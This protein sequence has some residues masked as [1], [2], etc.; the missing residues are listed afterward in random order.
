MRGHLGL[1]T[2]V[3]LDKGHRI[4]QLMEKHG[5]HRLFDVPFGD[6][7]TINRSLAHTIRR[8]LDAHDSPRNE[9]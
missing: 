2:V 9:E 1:F 8:F 7:R 5:Q 6:I 4:A 3:S